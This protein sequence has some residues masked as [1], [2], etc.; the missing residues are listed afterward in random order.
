MSVRIKEMEQNKMTNQEQEQ[1][2]NATLAQLH[3]GLITEDEAVTIITEGLS[4]T[5]VETSI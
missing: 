1:F 4:G 2:I 5:A 3:A